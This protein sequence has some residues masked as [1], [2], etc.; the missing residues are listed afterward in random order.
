MRSI[1]VGLILLSTSMSAA[2][3]SQTQKHP[4]RLPGDSHRRALI[5][6]LG[7]ALDRQWAQNDLE[8][9]AADN[10]RLDPPARD[11]V[12]GVGQVHSRE[13]ALTRRIERDNARLDREIEGICS[14]C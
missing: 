14:G 13:D 11:S 10:Q 4:Q 5:D 8:K 1:F 2:D 9:V 3:A 7:S 6:H 12:I